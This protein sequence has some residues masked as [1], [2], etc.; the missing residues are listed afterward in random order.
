MVGARHRR[1]RA[2][3]RAAHRHVHAARPTAG[4]AIEV[5]RVGRGAGR[6]RP[7]RRRRADP[8]AGPG[9]ARRRRRRRRRPGRQAR[10]RL[11]DGRLEGDDPR[12][13]RRPRRRRCRGPGAARRHRPVVR[14]CSP[15]ST[16]WRSAWPPGGSAPAGPARRT[17]CRPVPASCWHARPGDQVTEGAAAVHAAHRRPGPVRPR[18]GLARRRLRH[19]AAGHVVR[20]RRRWSSTASAELGR[21][22][23]PSVLAQ[24]RLASTAP[25]TAAAGRRSRRRRRAWPRPR[26]RSC[27]A[28][29]DLLAGRA[30]R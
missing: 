23:R 25:L 22:N 18:P 11:G 7:G 12:P 6:R 26:S 4:N 13:G 17:R 24:N 10:R 9:D 15:A 20:T 5:A 27:S 19:R 28:S 1:R 16:R 3:R 29:V 21:R 8:G 2:H 30:G 14:A